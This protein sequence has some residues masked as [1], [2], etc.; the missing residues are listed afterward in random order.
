MSQAHRIHWEDAYRVIEPQIDASGVHVWPFDRA[1]PLDVRW[2]AFQGKSSIA[3]NRH[4][5]YELLYLHSGEVVYQIQDQFVR[6]REGDLFIMGSTL[7]HRISEYKTPRVRAAVLYFMPDLI[8]QDDSAGNSL[9][10]LMPF[11]VQRSG[12]PHIVPAASGVPAQVFDLMKRAQGELPAAAAR[13]QLSIK[14]YLK[15]MLVLLVNH[16]ADYRGV[17][18][19]VTRRERALERL[20]PLFDYLDEHYA[21]PISIDHAAGLL[22]MSRSHFMRFFRSMTG[23]PLIA[24]VNRLRVAKA[25]ALLTRTDKPISMVSQEVGFCD[26]SYFGLIFRRLVGMTPREYT[27]AMA[28]L[29][30]DAAAATLPDAAAVTPASDGLDAI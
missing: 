7:F 15:M 21:E 3:L 10:Y 13:A 9:E 28:Q 12:F 20:R 26:Q 14:T 22:G 30:T 19:V 4:D 2:L 8:R 1:F 11:L 5:Y 18:Q 24:H 29:D 17:S 6:M 27:A 25:Q 23:Q 16:Y